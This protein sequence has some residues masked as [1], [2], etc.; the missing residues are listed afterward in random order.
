LGCE[1][2]HYR[3][4]REQAGLISSAGKEGKETGVGRE[5]ELDHS[6]CVRIPVDS[7]IDTIRANLPRGRSRQNEPDINRDAD[8]S[9]LIIS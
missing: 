1:T 5:N 7:G 3:F 8:A 4:D 6:G 9:W 2:L